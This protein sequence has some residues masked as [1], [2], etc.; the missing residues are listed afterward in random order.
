[1]TKKLNRCILIFPAC[2]ALN[3]VERVREKYDPSYLS[4]AAHITLVFPFESG[5][6]KERVEKHLQ[7]AFKG[8][9]PFEISLG[10]VKRVTSE[11]GLFLFLKVNRGVSKLKKLHDRLYGGIVKRY[12]PDWLKKVE[13]LPHMTLG[14]FESKTELDAAYEEVK[15]KKAVKQGFS[16]GVKK[17]SVELI[18]ENG[19]SEIESE[20]FLK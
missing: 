5:I 13:F 1:M 3:A 11:K 18:G 16:C 9:K 6:S 8:I 20:I 2:K 17:I 7:S 15:H 4:V 19:E 10:G 12:H 14:K